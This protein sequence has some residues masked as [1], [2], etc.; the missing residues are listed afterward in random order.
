MEYEISDQPDH[1]HAS[2]PDH[3]PEPAP[4]AIPAAARDRKAMVIP[5]EERHH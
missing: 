1:R 3:Q 2:V 5:E 4:A